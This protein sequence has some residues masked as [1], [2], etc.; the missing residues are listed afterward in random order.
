MNNSVPQFM[1]QKQTESFL[2]TRGGNRGTTFDA[3]EGFE[4]NNNNYVPGNN[5][6][7]IN[8]AS[9]TNNI[10]VPYSSQ[11]KNFYK[12]DKILNGD[13]FKGWNDTYFFQSSVFRQN[14]DFWINPFKPTFK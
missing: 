12:G 5:V 7:T 1:N 2:L 8:L 10:Q 3:W 4:D 13:Y 9:N 11:Y 14:M 6:N